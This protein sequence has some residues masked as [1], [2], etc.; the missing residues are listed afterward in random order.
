MGSVGLVLLF[1]HG[2]QIL[3]GSVMIG[4]FL[5]VFRVI[6]ITPQTAAERVGR[7]PH[8]PIDQ[9]LWGRRVA[10]SAELLQVAAFLSVVAG[11]SCTLSLLTDRAYRDE[12]LDDVVREV[13]QALA[14]RA[15]CLR[16]LAER[17]G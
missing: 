5:I 8:L 14:L 12:F 7:G 3:I 9:R 15:L 13:R 2:L 10:L 11:F 16:A 17:R 6:A 1:S 4:V